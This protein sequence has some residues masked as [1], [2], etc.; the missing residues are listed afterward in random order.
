M[1][2]HLGEIRNLRSSSIDVD[3][4][5]FKISMENDLADCEIL[6]SS[7]TIVECDKGPYRIPD[8]PISGKHC[9]DISSTR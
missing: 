3:P 5:E 7:E 9:E 2:E 4:E 8:L 6:S 1:T